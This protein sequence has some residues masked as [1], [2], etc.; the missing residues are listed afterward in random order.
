MSADC[1]VCRTLERFRK[2]S[3]GKDRDA[4]LVV[5]GIA[6]GLYRS[7]ASAERELGFCERHAA[8]YERTKGPAP[9]P[10][11]RRAS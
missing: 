11:D 2:I 7:E 6:S 4:G 8:L 10:A 3:P 5:V 1:F 9:L